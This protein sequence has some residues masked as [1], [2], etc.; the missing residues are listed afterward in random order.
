MV[1]GLW[2]AWNALKLY[3]DRNRDQA[4]RVFFSTLAYLPVVLGVMVLD[5]GPSVPSPELYEAMNPYPVTERPV[6][7]PFKNETTSESD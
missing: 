5:R 7:D 2:M 3:L 6:V 4:R 1:M